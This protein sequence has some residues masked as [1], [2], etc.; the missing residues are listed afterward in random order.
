LHV[1]YRQCINQRFPNRLKLFACKLF[2]LCIHITHPVKEL[3]AQ[4]GI[5]FNSKGKSFYDLL[6][7]CLPLFFSCV[8]SPT[9]AF[10]KVVIHLRR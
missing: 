4:P 8:P 6:N 10:L 3:P 5:V 2:S 7:L 9:T 1:R